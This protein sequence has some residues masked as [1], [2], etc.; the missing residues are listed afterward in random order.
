MVAILVVAASW[1]VL[2]LNSGPQ[3]SDGHLSISVGGG[4]GFLMLLNT[5]GVIWRVQKCL[6][7]WTRESVEPDVFDRPVESEYSRY[8]SD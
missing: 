6:I 7:A 2:A 8:E 4:I 5:W 3:S 1:I